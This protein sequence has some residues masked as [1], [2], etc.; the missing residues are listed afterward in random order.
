[1]RSKAIASAGAPS[2]DAAPPVAPLA[3]VADAGDSA[4]DTSALERRAGAGLVRFVGA[5]PRGAAPD[6]GD[7]PAGGFSFALIGPKLSG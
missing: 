7:A 3:P 6:L 4:D 5:R 2:D 1:M